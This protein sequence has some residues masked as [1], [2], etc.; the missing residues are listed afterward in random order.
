MNRLELGGEWLGIER[1]MCGADGSYSAEWSFGT[2]VGEDDQRLGGQ[3]E[4]RRELPVAHEED[5]GEL[6][7]CGVVG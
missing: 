7:L 6:L 4:G 1:L 5:R 2:T 3:G